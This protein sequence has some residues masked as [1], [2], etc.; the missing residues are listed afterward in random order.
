MVLSGPATPEQPV[1]DARGDRS[2]EALD[3]STA[4]M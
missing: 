4:L 2:V 3:A 1:A